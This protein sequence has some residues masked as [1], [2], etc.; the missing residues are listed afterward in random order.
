MKPLFRT[1]LLALVFAVT[2]QLFTASA[3]IPRFLPPVSYTVPGA[4]MVAVA[5]LN[6]DGI[7]DLVTANELA[8]NGDG[9]VSILL[10]IGH[11]TFHPAKQIVKGGSPGWVLVGD[12]NNDGKPDIAVANEPDPSQFLPV[13]GGPAPNSVSIL[14]GNGD[15]TFQPSIDTATS[16]A[17]QMA[18]AD[19]NGDGKL[20]LA[21]V[22]GDSLPLQILLNHGDGR[23][24]VSDTTINSFT[25]VLVGDFNKDGKQDFIANGFVMLGNGDGTFTVG[26]G[27]DLFPVLQADFDGDGIQ[28]LATVSGS[29]GRLI[30]S[31]ISMGLPGGNFAPSFIS[32][33]SGY[34]IVAA[35]F[36][37]D[38]KIDVFGTGGPTGDGIDPPIGGLALGVGDGTFTFGAPGFGAPLASGF[39]SAF[40]AIGDFDGNG[41]PDIAITNGFAVLVALNTFGHPPLLAQLTTDTTFVV[42]GTTTIKGTVSLGAPAPAGGVIVTLA[43]NK[44]AAATLPKTVKIPAG[45]VSASFTI[46][47][48]AVTVPTPVTITATYHFTKL[49]TN[50]NVVAPFT[51]A[52]VSVSPSSLIGMFGGDAAV[53]TVT[54]SGPAPNGTVV[55]LSS[56]NSA[57]VT[58]PA[59]VAFAPGATTATFPVSAQHVTANTTV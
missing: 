16:G 36:N 37:G 41:S 21:V 49:T 42:G 44:I 6:G 38:G 13:T 33:L 26:Q 30:I 5:D 11:G 54:L 58:V 4:A 25:R 9:G 59:S 46:S 51:V 12:F 45:T 18:A 2:G 22:T 24:T 10:G 55:N 29:V 56:A 3:Q 23:F 57:V 20:D 14:L 31:N 19:F 32:S 52:S 15:G 17:V 53:G 1:S 47:T 28:D 43:S 39:R 27:L 35:D 34:E 40:P 8:P 7:L 48:N 50:I